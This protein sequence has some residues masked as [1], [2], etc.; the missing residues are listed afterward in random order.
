MKY[1]IGYIDED[2]KEVTKLRRRLR[3]L[4]INVINY[5]FKKNMTIDELMKQVYDSDI[6]LLM[7]DY[8]LKGPLVTFNGE[9][10]EKDL[11]EKKPQ[12][13]YIIF[14]S[15]RP[16]AEHFIEDWKS[17]YDKEVLSNSSDPAD[18]VH[19]A[20]IL[21]K[22]IDQYKNL[23]SKKKERLATLL[24]K[25]ENEGLNAAE[26]STLLNV[27]EDLQRLNQ[28]TPTEIPAQLHSYDKIEELSTVRKE[29]EKFL[30]SL[31]NSGETN[32]S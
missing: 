2:K 5:K 8:K 17:I 27:Q 12:F 25:G 19:F 31:I 11:Y 14:T 20:N 10:I 32:E 9:K 1:R 30:K 4:D 6:E 28:T 7:I 21:K 13:P 26:K 16:D 18:Q 23:I 22:S 24:I 15:Y 29:A 3:D